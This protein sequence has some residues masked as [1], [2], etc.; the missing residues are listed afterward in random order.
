MSLFSS[1]TV[2]L[3]GSVASWWRQNLQ[4]N[5]KEM[6]P[7]IGWIRKNG[8]YSLILARQIED[9]TQFLKLIHVESNFPRKYDF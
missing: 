6:P 8:G 2:T 1:Y 3:R 4:N 5:A 9:D 7:K